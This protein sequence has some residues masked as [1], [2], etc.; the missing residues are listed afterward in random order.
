MAEIPPPHEQTDADEHYIDEPATGDTSGDIPLTDTERK[1]AAAYAFFAHCEKDKKYAA[2]DAY[3]QAKLR[4]H[5]AH[6]F[7]R[8]AM[9]HNE[10]DAGDVLHPGEVRNNINRFQDRYGAVPPHDPNKLR[11][12]VNFQSENMATAGAFNNVREI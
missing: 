8:A 9:H 3:G 10:P 12:R 1:Y 2:A 6:D 5:L 4:P 11:S 7:V